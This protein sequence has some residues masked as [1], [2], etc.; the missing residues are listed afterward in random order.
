[1]ARIEED[2]I[3]QSTT[4]KG[5]TSI[6]DERSGDPTKYDKEILVSGS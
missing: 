1:V 6:T 2:S 5:I 3:Q 4:N